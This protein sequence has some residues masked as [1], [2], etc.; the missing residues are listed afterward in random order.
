MLV[1]LSHVYYTIFLTE[2]LD[3]HVTP[4]TTT[5]R[6]VRTFSQL[7][8][9]R[10]LLDEIASAGYITP[11]PIQAQTIPVELAGHD[12]IALAKTGKFQLLLL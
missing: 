3:V 2:Q 12:V 1:F 5:P 9:D 6:P 7:N 8:F 10:Q 11:T 4:T